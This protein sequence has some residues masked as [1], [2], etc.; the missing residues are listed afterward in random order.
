MRLIRY[1]R[2]HVPCQPLVDRIDVLVPSRGDVCIHISS[3][4]QR[5]TPMTIA[6]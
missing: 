3:A 5:E 1:L 4:R 2:L 6:I